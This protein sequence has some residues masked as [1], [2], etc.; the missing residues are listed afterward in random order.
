ML[1]L[2][3]VVKRQLPKLLYCKFA[4][5]GIVHKYTIVVNKYTIVVNK[6]TIVNKYSIVVNKYMIVIA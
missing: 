1:M 2:C 5:V 3:S 6:Y 4:T